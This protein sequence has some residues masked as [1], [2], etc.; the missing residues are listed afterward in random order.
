MDMENNEQNAAF[1]AFTI[2]N[3]LHLITKLTNITRNKT[4]KINLLI[5]G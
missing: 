5:S 3:K 2:D 4:R 1:A